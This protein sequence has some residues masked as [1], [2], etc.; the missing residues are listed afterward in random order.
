MKKTVLLLLLISLSLFL[1]ASP[2]RERMEALEAKEHASSLPISDSSPLLSLIHEAY[3]E[4]ENTVITLEYS[5]SSLLFSSVSPEKE[6]ILSSDKDDTALFVDGER[7]S[8]G[9]IR[10]NAVLLLPSL[11]AAYS[12]LEDQSLFQ[13]KKKLS[14]IGDGWNT[15]IIFPES[16]KEAECTFT[17]VDS[18]KDSWKVLGRIEK[19]K[20][21]LSFSPTSIFRLPHF[22]LDE[23]QKNGEERNGIYW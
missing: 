2:S 9:N 15:T 1:G 11:E 14:Y 22:I 7:V 20:I 19:D 21:P 18:N 16:G 13:T 8:K 17:F 12:A 5:A 23:V 4:E 6:I 3:L 10:E